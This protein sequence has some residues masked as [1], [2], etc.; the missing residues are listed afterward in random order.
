M[1]TPTITR[2]QNDTV[3][4]LAKRLRYSLEGPDAG[5]KNARTRTAAAPSE[6]ASHLRLKEHLAGHGEQGVS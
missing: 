1:M 6:A 3:S 5:I 2:R 4:S